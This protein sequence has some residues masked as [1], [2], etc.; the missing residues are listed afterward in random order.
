MAAR[1]ACTVPVR[2]DDLSWRFK[3]S[4]GQFHVWHAGYLDYRVTDGAQGPVVRQKQQFGEAWSDATR[5]YD[6][7]RLGVAIE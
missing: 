4:V 7:V 3:G 2:A 1:K 5:R 6:V